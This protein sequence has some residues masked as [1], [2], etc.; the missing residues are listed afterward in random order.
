MSEKPNVDPD[1]VLR[2]CLAAETPD[3]RA[4]AAEN[5]KTVCL[6]LHYEAD[7]LAEAQDEEWFD[8]GTDKH[9]KHLRTYEK[10]C[11]ALRQ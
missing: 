7:L 3:E 4:K 1:A 10:S 9:L 8:R 2:Q 5:V 11:D 6:L